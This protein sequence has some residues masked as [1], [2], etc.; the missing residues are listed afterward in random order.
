MAGPLQRLHTAIDEVL[1][2]DPLGLSDAGLLACLGEVERGARRL[3][4]ARHG[5]VA[6]IDTRGI[7]EHH[8]V[9]STA[10]LLRDQLRLSGGEAGMWVRQASEQVGRRDLTT[11]AARAAKLPAV[12]AAVQTGA[13][14][15][16]QTQILSTTM[17]HVPAI[18]SPE[19]RTRLEADLV[20]HAH[21]LGP[22]LL[23]AVCRHALHVLDQDGKKPSETEREARVGLV[24]GRTRID[25]LTPFKG[26]ADPE[27]KA[28]LQAA[29]APLAKPVPSD[30]GRDT[31]SHATRM[32]HALRDLALRALAAGNLPS[33]A[34][35]PAT[36]L[37]T[38]TLE[39]LEARTGLVSVLNGGTVPVAEVIRMAANMNV[40][41]IVFSAAG[42]I[43]HCGQEQR[44][45]TLPMRRA[46]A[47][48]DRGCVIPG[49]DIP[50]MFC[51][52]HH[53]TDFVD[54]GE[55]DVD[56]LAWVCPYHHRRID[57]WHLERRGGRVW[58]TAPPWLDPTQTPRLNSY[59]YPPDL[60]TDDDHRAAASHQHH[61]PT[62]PPGRTDQ[63]RPA[64][65][66][67]TRTTNGPK[68]DIGTGT[69]PP[70]LFA[71]HY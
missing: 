65:P 49:C 45:G 64:P 54:G 4:G 66:D 12:A 30:L 71:P 27:T 37:L 20:G 67:P 41:P 57:G 39:Q 69:A 26:I 15:P 51:Q 23:A 44:L 16:E 29:L 18:V 25:G 48:Q 28:A 40:V 58:C 35:L 33:M 31:R 3:P 9:R 59:F 68:I 21:E 5:L 7:A 17:R 38:A 32:I 19:Q 22:E 34:G 62:R 53:T 8:Q 6:E 70:D 47:A 46:T 2:V 11:G 60:L 63:R 61:S 56:H 13:L 52:H 50:I 14:S 36:L 1:A 55:T 43:L 10:V 42:Q 24:F